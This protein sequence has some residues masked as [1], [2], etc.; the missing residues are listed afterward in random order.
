MLV[1]SVHASVC[2][3]YIRLTENSLTIPT[4]NH[5]IYTYLKSFI[6]LRAM[7]MESQQ[8]WNIYMEAKKCLTN[9]LIQQYL[10]ASY[11]P[12]ISLNS[13]FLCTEEA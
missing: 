7:L 12:V 1:A 5:V 9:Q 4:V 13:S 2:G 6:F 11:L 8:I 10:C 3:N